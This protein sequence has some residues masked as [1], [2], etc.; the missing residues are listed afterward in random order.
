M[1]WFPHLEFFK[2]FYCIYKSIQPPHHC[3]QILVWLGRPS[4]A[5]SHSPSLFIYYASP[6]PFCSVNSP[7]LFPHQGT[8]SFCLDCSSLRSLYDHRTIPSQLK[9]LLREIS[10]PPYPKQRLSTP[11]LPITSS[12][13]DDFTV[14]SYECSTWEG[15]VCS[16]P[17]CHPG[18]DVSP[19]RDS[20]ILFWRTVF[21]R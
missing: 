13:P 15:L 19:L 17:V 1:S 18:E 11:S 3:L 10:W 2:S 14:I 20:N 8:C 9:C 16:F 12:C 7:E 5:T 6:T 4:P 21:R